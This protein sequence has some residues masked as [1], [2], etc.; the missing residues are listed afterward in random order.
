MLEL[1][2]RA[3]RDIAP[4]VVHLPDW[5]DEP[6]QKRLVRAVRGWAA[7]GPLAAPGESGPVSTSRFTLFVGP[8]VVRLILLKR[9]GLTGSAPIRPQ[10]SRHEAAPG[11]G[12]AFTVPLPRCDLFATRVLGACNCGAGGWDSPVPFRAARAT[13]GWLGRFGTRLPGS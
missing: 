12:P 10:A 3:R 8:A 1:F 2:P 7:V 6:R 9:S 4:G 13:G 5:L 11:P